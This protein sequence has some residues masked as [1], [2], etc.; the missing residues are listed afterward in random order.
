[1][2]ANKQ[3]SSNGVQYAMY[4][5]PVMNITQTI[6]GYYS[7]RG[8]N[9]ID[10]AQADS[11][12]SNG[13]A[14]CDMVCVATDYGDAYG[15]AMFWQSTA[16][17]MT[18]SHGQQYI[19]M[20]VIHDNTADA[21]VGLTVSQGQQLFSEGTAGNATGNHNHIEVALGQWTGTHYVAS[22][23]VTAWGTTVWMLPGNINPA[24]VFFVDD[25]TI[26][27]NGDLDWSSTSGAGSTSCNFN[28]DQLIEE[29]AVATFTVDQL[30][31]RVNDPN[32]EICRQYNT[33]DS[34]EYHYKWVGNGHRYICWYE[35]SNIIMVAVNGNEEGTEPWATFGEVTESVD[36]VEEEGWAKYKVD[37]VVIRQNAYNGEIVGYAST[38]TV[39]HYAYKCVTSE[40]RYIVYV[41]DG[42]NY[43]VACSPSTERS[44][45]WCDFYDS[46]P[47]G[48]TEDV[49]TD[50]IPK[51]TTENVKHWGIDLSEHNSS[52]LDVTK[53]D[54]AII[55]ASY[56]ENTDAK[57]D[58]F[59]KKCESFNI[60]YGLYHYSYAISDDES[61]AETKYFLD[62]A[63]KYNPELGVWFDMEDADNYKSKNN[64][65]DREHV[66]K[67]TQNFCMKAKA[68]GYYVGVYSS[69]WWFDNWLNEGI[70]EYDKWVAQWDS[71]DGDYHS[72]TSSR[73]T[74]HQYTSID[75]DTGTSLDKNAMYVDFNHYKE[76]KNDTDQDTNDDDNSTNTDKT[77]SVLVKLIKFIIQILKKLFAKK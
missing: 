35:G 39:I 64:V 1:M 76:D 19:T 41:Q 30:N 74:I 56:G 26:I 67:W 60:P 54:F 13:Y 25:T 2:Q 17:V 15:N 14:P 23:G 46:E 7:H 29:R 38:D 49:T 50:D 61:D 77:T 71:N 6:N 22:G 51:V 16:P 32:G 33:G 24:E 70:D 66:L 59:V 63:A 40:H 36:L 47:S 48:D 5:N 28:T 55:R 27:N 43:Y 34:I 69:T 8:T 57:L 18:R 9:A 12:I 42:V 62:L 10:D 65:L 58:H 11:G 53:Y 44:T 31:A 68:E 72:D 75:K 3:Y 4:P 45:E 37:E 20:M 21:Y 52:D 73:G